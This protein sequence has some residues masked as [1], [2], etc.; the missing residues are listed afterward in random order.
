MIERK[1]K[2]G[3]IARTYIVYRQEEVDG[4]LYPCE[5]LADSVPTFVSDAAVVVCVTDPALVPAEDEFELE[6]K[7]R[8]AAADA[9]NKDKNKNKNKNKKNKKNKNNQCQE[10][11]EVLVVAHPTH[12]DDDNMT[13]VTYMSIT[14]LDKK[15]EVDIDTELFDEV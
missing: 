4:F 1:D 11:G 14:S 10:E 2:E 15:F 5:Y 7:R 3:V 8:T 12:D 6:Q 9:P 13:L